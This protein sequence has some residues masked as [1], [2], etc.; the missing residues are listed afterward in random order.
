VTPTPTDAP[1]TFADLLRF[2]GHAELVAGRIVAM[3]PESAGPGVESHL[4]AP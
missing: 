1:A 4:P 2:D 3:T